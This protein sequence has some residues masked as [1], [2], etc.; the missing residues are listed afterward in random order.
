MMTAFGSIKIP[1]QTLGFI[2]SLVINHHLSIYLC[3][4]S[5]YFSIYL[6][7]YVDIHVYMSL[8]MSIY[9]WKYI[10]RYVSIH[11]SI[12]LSMYLSMYISIYVSIYMSMH[13]SIYLSI[14][15]SCKEQKKEAGQDC[16]V[17]KFEVSSAEL[18]RP[19][20]LRH[21]DYQVRRSFMLRSLSLDLEKTR[22][23]PLSIINNERI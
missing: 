18:T 2:R 15:I 12:Y 20:L 11:V 9:V 16:R 10:S 21:L 4:P 13:I 19:D 7:I 17:L 22:C 6:F 3:T 8:H 14:Y 1:R 5:I 23:L